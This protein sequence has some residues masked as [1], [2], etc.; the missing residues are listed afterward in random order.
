MSIDYDVAVVGAGPIGLAA[1]ILIARQSGISPRRVVVFD[2]R[3]PESLDRAKELPVDLRVFALSRASER[4]LRACDA[5]D[6]I[7]ANRTERYERMHV[8]HA[9]V[10]LQLF[11]PSQWILASS[12][13]LAVCTAAVL[14]NIAAAVA[15]AAPVT[16]LDIMQSLLR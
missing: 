14:N 10:P 3:P 5:W 6:E 13:A 12:A 9:D 4:I 1:A 16:R 15:R 8:W 11:T 7:A 2:R